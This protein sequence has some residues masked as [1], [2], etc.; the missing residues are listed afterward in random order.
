MTFLT[1][2]ESTADGSHLAAQLYSQLQDRGLTVR[3]L[4]ADD[5]KGIFASARLAGLIIIAPKGGTD[6]LFLENAFLLLKRAAPALRQAGEA[7]GAL[8]ATVSRLDGSFGCLDGSTLVD[9]L[10]GGLAGL[11]KTAA[12]EWPEVA[13]GR[14][15]WGTSQ[16]GCGHQTPWRTNCGRRR[17]GNRSGHRDGGADAG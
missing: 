2:L 1:H 9:P 3:L 10:S 5:D 7:E 4:A 6:D 17:G 11:V 13:C 16:S 14:S 15:I 8:F 12:R